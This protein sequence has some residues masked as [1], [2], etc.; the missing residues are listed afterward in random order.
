MYAALGAGPGFSTA[1]LDRFDALRKRFPDDPLLKSG[2]V[3]LYADGVVES[4]TAAMLAP[5]ANRNTTG[6]SNF[7]PAELTR[8]V[9]MLDGHG[10]QVMTHAIGDR[11][12]RM[13]LDAY[14]HA[15]TANKAPERGRRHRI[16]H[17]ETLDPDDLPRL[18]LHSCCLPCWRSAL[19]TPI[20]TTWTA[21]VRVRIEPRAMPASR[22]ACRSRKL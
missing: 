7:T 2:A 4:Y 18:R 17:I 12:I 20:R 1:D 3:K 5:Y 16:E 11:A 13:T 8:I 14:D 6:T 9:T 15:A 21:R 19:A 10:W 22:H